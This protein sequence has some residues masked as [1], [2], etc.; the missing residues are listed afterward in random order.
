MLIPCGSK[1]FVKIALSGTISKINAFLC[2]TQKFKM[3]TKSGG[4]IIFEKSRQ[5]TLLTPGGQKT[6]NFD[7]ITLS[8]TILEINVFLHVIQKFNM[9]CQ[10]VRK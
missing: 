7:E 5:Y 1:N 2:F 9:A 10:S 3:A 4:K 6:K 8:H